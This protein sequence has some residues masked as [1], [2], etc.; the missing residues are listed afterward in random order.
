M[1]QPRYS[2][3]NRSGVCVC[4]H[5]WAV[6]HLGVVMNQSYYTD[7]GE[8]YLPQECEFCGV[9]EDGGKD[10]EGNYHCNGYRDTKDVA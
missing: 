10:A 3:P 6:H 9:N 7:T 4:G 5:S 8:E 2:G 1:K